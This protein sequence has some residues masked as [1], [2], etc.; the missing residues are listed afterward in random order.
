MSIHIRRRFVFFSFIFL[1]L[2]SQTATATVIEYSVDNLGGNRYQYNYSIINDTN[3]ATVDELAIFFDYGFYENLSVEA[4]PVDWDTLA[5][6]PDMILNIPEDGF[7]DTLA[8]VS[9]LAYGERLDGLTISFDWLG[10]GGPTAQFFDV[11]DPTT[12]ES[13]ETGVTTPATTAAPV[14]E[15]ATMFLLGSGILGMLGFRRKK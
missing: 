6:N 7:I 8:L 11:L 10:V 15:P 14:P 5:I 4:S 3:G 9:G 12:F 13:L 1:L 2:L